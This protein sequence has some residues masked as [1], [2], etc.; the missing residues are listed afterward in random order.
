MAEYK[1]D[2]YDGKYTIVYN[3]GCDGKPCNFKALRYGEDWRDL[4]G[5]GMILALIHHIQHQE[6]KIK[7]LEDK[8]L[9]LEVDY[10]SLK[11]DTD[12]EERTKQ[13][14]KAMG[15]IDRK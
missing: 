1:L 14:N 2:I 12:V 13:F 6:E 5:D 15:R 3:D 4:I 11:V 8:N 7:E 10:V 9:K